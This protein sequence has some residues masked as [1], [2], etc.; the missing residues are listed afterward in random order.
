MMSTRVAVIAITLVVTAPVRSSAQ[1]PG[2]R[3]FVSGEVL[4]VRRRQ[5]A[6]GCARAARLAA[7]DVERT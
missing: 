1:T 6:A 5:N 7:G 3:R 4:E 2:S